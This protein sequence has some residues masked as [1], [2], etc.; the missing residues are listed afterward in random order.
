MLGGR[1]DPPHVGHLLAAQHAAERLDLDEVWF[2]PAAE[3][4]HKGTDA[5]AEHR[6]AMTLLAT[7]D[8]PSFRASRLELDREG[9]SYTIDTVHEIKASWEHVDL[10]LIVGADAAAGLATW[11]RP[12]ELVRSC[13]VVVL[14]R[15]GSDLGDLDPSLRRHLTELEP[16][17][18]AVSAS[19][20]RERIRDGRSV[21]Y[22]V[23]R[24][25]EDY[26]RKHGLY[27]HRTRAN[28]A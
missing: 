12:E 27:G 15:P 21:R 1:F 19:E 14:A 13:T 3:P 5:D 17:L 23:P 20:I 2:V 24:S 18:V 7:A 11:H 4:P 22:L 28:G 10:H 26:V 16:R 8:H 9:P 6:H 25:V